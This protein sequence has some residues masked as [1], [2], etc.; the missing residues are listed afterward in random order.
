MDKNTIDEMDKNT[1]DQPLVAVWR[2]L[3]PPTFPGTQHRVYRKFFIPKI[4]DWDF[5]G[6]PASWGEGTRDA[7]EDDFF[8]GGER[9]DVDRLDLVLLVEVGQITVR[10]HIADCNRSHSF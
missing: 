5:E 4:E 8:T 3:Y 9:V 7:K 10:Y 2:S 6:L 1:I